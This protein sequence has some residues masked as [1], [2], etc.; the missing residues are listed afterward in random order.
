MFFEAK[1]DHISALSSDRLV[2]LMKRLLLAE[3]RTFAIPLRSTTVPLQITIADGGEDGRVSWE[4]GVPA[5]D[6]VPSRFT[7]F[8]AKATN[9][10]EASVSSEVAKPSAKGR[11]RINDAVAEAIRQQGAYVIVSS[12][13]YTGQKIGRLRDE[14]ASTI[15]SCGAVIP[16]RFR[17]DIYDANKLASWVNSHPPIALWLAEIGR[18]RSVVG[19]QSHDSWAR[20]PEIHRNNWVADDDPRFVPRDVDIDVSERREKSRNAWTFRQAAEHIH[21]FLSKR[22]RVLRIVGP[23]GFGKSRFAFELF[24]Q[25]SAIADAIESA[26]LLYAD[27]RVAGEEAIKL[28]VEIADSGLS[29][30]MV[31]DECSDE[32]HATFVNCSRR[33]GSKLRLVTIDVESEV[34]TAGDTL[35]V[36]LEEASDQTISAIA[37]NVAPTLSDAALRLIEQF[38]HGFPRMAVLAAPRGGVGKNAVRSVAEFVERI[39]WGRRRFNADAQK[40]LEVASLF[41]W[42]GLDGGAANEASFVAESLAR[43]SREAFLEH[44]RS[45]VD[46]GIVS[47]KGDFVQIAPAPLAAVLGAKRVAVLPEDAL[48][49]FWSMAPERL[50]KSLLRRMRWLDEANHARSFAK[51]LLQPSRL[52]NVAQ[53]S[54]EFGADCIDRLVHID[55]DTSIET[56]FRLINGLDA[57]GLKGLGAGRRHLVWALEK[58]AFR[59]DSF[60][61]AA[62][63]LRRL[64]TVETEEKIS[65]NATGQ[66]R[67]LFQIYLSG[68][69]AAPRDRLL[70]LDEGLLSTDPNELFVCLGALDQMLATHHFS[71]SA[72]AEELGSGAPME[73]WSPSAHTEIQGYLQAA[74][75]RLSVI[76]SGPEPF[77]NRA[78]GIVASH[79]RGLL[80]QIPL[81]KI[82]VLI[83]E[84]GRHQ[85]WIEAIQGV[86]SWLYFDSSRAPKPLRTQVRDFYRALLPSDPVDLAFLH[87]SS[88]SSELH[89]PDTTYQQGE[90]SGFDFEYGHRQLVQL[91]DIVSQS[92]ALIDA[93]VQR[94][95]IGES[96]TCFAFAK[97][98]AEQAPKPSEIFASALTRLEGGIE[99]ANRQFFAGLI[100]GIYSRD[101]SAARRCVQLALRSKALKDN[102]IGLIGAGKLSKRDL[103]IVISLLDTGDVQPWQCVPLSYGRGLDHLAPDELCPLLDALS[104]KGGAGL[105]AMLEIVHMYLHGD[106]DF[107]KKLARRVRVALASPQLFKVTMRRDL[108]GHNFEVLVGKLVRLKQLEPG[109]VRDIA[110]QLTR[111]LRKEHSNAWNAMGDSCQKVLGFLIEADGAAVWRCVAKAAD[112]SN[113]FVQHRLQDL[114]EPDD[115]DA[116][117]AGPLFQLSSHVYLDWVR[118]KPQGRASFVMQWLPIAAKDSAGAFIWNPAALAFLG[119]FGRLNGVLG[120]LTQRLYP[121]GWWGPVGPHLQP[122]IEL[123]N[124]LQSHAAPALR[125]YA[126]EQIR[127]FREEAIADD[128]RHD[129]DVVRFS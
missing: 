51:R 5:T 101:P 124:E 73:D 123:L 105:W 120:V 28:A 114:V 15:R 31:V 38:S 30:T 100:S 11:R 102:A 4:G 121:S 49:S 59:R 7:V 75:D 126:A 39:V 67:Q 76:A 21:A 68:T 53:L 79:I 52:G 128:R 99:A 87:S 36:T 43:T 57:A 95:A 33:A 27:L 104:D 41:E 85:T 110:T 55:P 107:P 83:T 106:K 90:A 14:I 74:L 35:V 60:V 6:Y 111:L 108:Q 127:T 40:A 1:P 37:R 46:R 10:Y 82:S 78:R 70:V 25:R 65:N 19:L 54:T 3:C 81:P 98:L 71:R 119:E 44:V 13:P 88:W 112:T 2:E 94:F 117:A 129:E 26:S 45:F 29:A 89:D 48:D 24:N 84:I 12:H 32:Q 69:Q 96:K 58:L 42:L 122:A 91:A 64:A 62:T 23:S 97:Q 66:F 103:S 50:K 115:K 116:L 18:G 63:L 92:P 118:K 8:Q 86:N 16:K 9:L 80:N 20:S 109:D 22:E 47:V 113:W 125:I 77:A 17:W 93:A 34:A 56:L 61:K 72:G